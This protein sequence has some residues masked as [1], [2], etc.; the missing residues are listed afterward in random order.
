MQALSMEMKTQVLL[1]TWDASRQRV[2]LLR[3]RECYC[4]SSSLR[5]NINN[6]KGIKKEQIWQPINIQI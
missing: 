3:D 6:S 1:Q 5:L 4:L 2:K